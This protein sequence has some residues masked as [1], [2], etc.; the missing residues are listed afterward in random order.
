M[1]GRRVAVGTVHVTLL[2]LERQGLIASEQAPR[3]GGQIGRPRLLYSLTPDGAGRLSEARSAYDHTS[4]WITLLE[5]QR[6][7][8]RQYAQSSHS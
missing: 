3:D 7:S 4:E 6:E 1:A 5:Y 8:R 2:R